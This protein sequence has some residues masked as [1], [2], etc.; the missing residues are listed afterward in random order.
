M[1]IDFFAQIRKAGIPASIKEYLT[2][3]EAFHKR[4]VFANHDDFYHIARLTLVKNE[5]HY[6]KFDLAFSAYFDGIDITP[7]ELLQQVPGEWLNRIKE[8][9]LTEEEKKQID[10]MGGWEK[11]METLKK[12]LE[13]QQRRHQGGSKWIGTAGTSPYGAYGFNPQGVRIGQRESRNRGAV[14]VWDKRQFRNLDDNVEIG[15]RN[16]KLALKRLRRFARTGAADQLDLEGTIMSTAKN[17]G[18]LDIKMIPERRNAVKVLI[19]FDV[20]GSMEDYVK[21][22]E[23]LFSAAKTEFKHLEYFYFH[24]FL[25]ESVW[26]DSRRRTNER[27]PLFEVINKYGR[28]YKLI[29]VG[30]AT[31][32]PYEITYPGGSVEHYNEEAGAVWLKRMLEAFPKT[33]WLNPT[34]NDRWRYYESIGITQNLMNDRMYSLSLS[35][36]DAAIRNLT[37]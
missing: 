21:V 25:Y 30:D 32:S 35:G 22:C 18:Y 33:A 4:L 27:T 13:E 1:L 5:S 10:A 23:E 12:R 24:N 26:K 15:P 37:K 34:P 3:I 9:N 36:L 19:F 14:K 16:I 17:A 20:G 28:E 31:M 29:F 8:L 6:D 7:D 11:L 2:L